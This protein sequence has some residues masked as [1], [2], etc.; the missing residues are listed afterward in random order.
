M[1]LQLAQY[2]AGVAALLLLVGADARAQLVASANDGK[3]KLING[4][5]TT[6]P[7]GPPSNV[8]LIDLKS[9]PPKIVAEIA[10]PNSVVGPPQNIAV[11]PDK[12]LLFVTSSTQIDPSDSTKTIPD[13]KLTIIDLKTKPPSVLATL[14]AGKGASG[15]AINPA[16]TLAIVANRMEGTLSTYTIKGK[17][18]ATGAKVDLGAPDSQPSGIVFVPGG[19][20]ALLTR[21]NEDRVQWLAIDGPKVEPSPQLLTVGPKPYS[22]DVTAKGDLAVVGTTGVGPTGSDDTLSVIDLSSGEP[23][24]GKQVAAGS[25]VEHLSISPNGQYVAASVMNGT[26]LAKT[27][28]LYNDF[29][30][31]RIFSLSN[32][33]LE[34]ITEA[35]IGHWCQGVAWADNRTVLAQCMV[36]QE[37]MTFRFDGRTLTSGA[38]IKVNGGPAGIKVIP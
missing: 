2:A 1:P 17:N 27:A 35:A 34:P 32:G 31:L 23:R 22:I 11:T 24:V 7:N 3:A 26:N 38:T 37:I 6:V 4:V 16:G 10:A 21:N 20:G 13:D 30:R 19:R 15:V 29:A 36:E 9:I 8:T 33:T 12:T 25:V 28:P 18:I 5:N 14:R